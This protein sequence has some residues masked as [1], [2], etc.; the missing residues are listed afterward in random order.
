MATLLTLVVFAFLYLKAAP[1][2]PYDPAPAVTAAVLPHIAAGFDPAQSGYQQFGRYL[3]NALQLDFGPSFRFRDY[4]V[5]ELL[6]RGAPITLAIVACALLLAVAL[7][8]VAGCAAGRYKRSWVDRGVSALAMIW[9][10]VPVFVLAPLLQLVFAVGLRWLPIAGWDGGWQHM[11][12]PVLAL[13]LPLAVAVGRLVRRRLSDVASVEPSIRH[14]IGIAL[15][16]V[17]TRLGTLLSAALALSIPL[18]RAFSLPGTGRYVA[19]GGTSQD[20]PLL[21]GAVLFYG[22][23]VVLVSLA[24]DLLRFALRGGEEAAIS[25]Q[26]PSWAILRR[27]PIAVAGA[28]LFLA[29]AAACFTLP[30]LLPSTLQDQDYNAVLTGPSFT[31]GHLLGADELGRDLL[32]QLLLCGGGSIRTALVVAAVAGAIL[33]VWRF[34]EAGGGLPLRRWG[35]LLQ[36]VLDAVPFLLLAIVLRGWWPAQ[37]SS[38][39]AST[40]SLVWLVLWLAL[41]CRWP[42]R[43]AICTAIPAS[44]VGETYLAYYHVSASEPLTTLGGLLDAGLGNMD[45]TPWQVLTTLAAIILVAG[46]AALVSARMRGNSAPG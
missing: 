46:S 40:I 42:V 7:G 28:G 31:S 44:L 17:S 25:A 8:L 10:F 16:A 24:G 41:R 38:P 26:N 45:G 5:A 3:W 21:A 20:Y 14:R 9:L 43:R 11:L 39:A 15:D 37:V 6:F 18:E 12:L 22:G 34:A 30:A 23:I 13:A 29:A 33:A 19:Q 27:D 1:R 4:T 2:G 35:G 36:G 32:L